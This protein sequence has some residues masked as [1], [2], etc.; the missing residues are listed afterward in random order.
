ML[1]APVEQP[2]I[3]ST[4]CLSPRLVCVARFGVLMHMMTTRMSSSFWRELLGGFRVLGSLLG[5][6]R[7]R[8]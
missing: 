8:T 6:W 3:E 5:F 7:A 1:M 4:I 2:A